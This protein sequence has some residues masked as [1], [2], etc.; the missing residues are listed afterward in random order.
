[1]NLT[2]EWGQFD[3]ILMAN[4][5]DRLPDPARCLERIHDYLNTGGILAITSPYTWL[6]EYTPKSK[7]L[8]GFLRDGQPVRTRD[9]LLELLSPAF[10]LIDSRNLPF[11]IREHDRKNQFSIADA[12]IWKKR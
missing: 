10:E 8:G 5:I 6:E 1:M 7:W 11:L 3:F 9:T 2:P 12:T 4:L